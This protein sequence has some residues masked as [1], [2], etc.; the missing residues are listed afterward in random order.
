MSTVKTRRPMTEDERAIA[1]ALRS[2]TFL[3]A[4]FDK[5]FA[6]SMWAEEAGEGGGITEKQAELLR[7]FAHRYRRQLPA[8]IA[9]MGLKK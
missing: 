1:N 9:A 6:R 4:S 2:V 3:P 5:R 7:V 8:K